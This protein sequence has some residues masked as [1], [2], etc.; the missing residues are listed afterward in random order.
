MNWFRTKSLQGNLGKSQFIILVKKKQYSVE[1]IANSTEIQ[2]SE[3]VD[4]L[5]ITIDNFLTFNEHVDNLCSTANYKVHLLW[6]IRLYLSLKKNAKL[7]CKAFINSQFNYV[8]M[9]WMCCRKKHYLKIQKIL[10]K[11][12]KVVHKSNRNCDEFLR[13]N[14]ESSVPLRHLL[15]LIFDV[16]KSLNNL[17]AEFMW[18]YTKRS[19]AKIT[20][21]KINFLRHQFSVIQSISILE[22]I[23]EQFA[24]IF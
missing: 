15:A 14:N 22:H 8:T 23:L 10:R 21:C 7:S 17:N 18:Q 20:C 12:L 16:L 6:R 2:E 11:A 4:W 5:G 9:L 19:F 3:K 24:L 1:L 13:D